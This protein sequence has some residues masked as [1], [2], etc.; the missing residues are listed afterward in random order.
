SDKVNSLPADH[1]AEKTELK[2][3]PTLIFCSSG[4][5]VSYLLWGIAQER[6]VSYPYQNEDAIE[7]GAER[8]KDSLFLELSNRMLSFLAALFVLLVTYQPSHKAPLYE[9]SYN[10]FTC[11]MS[12]WCQYEA[13]KYVSFPLQVLVKASKIIPVMLMGRLVS[14]KSYSNF[15]YFT[16]VLMSL[17]LFMFIIVKR[18]SFLNLSVV[19][20]SIL[21]VGYMGFDSFTSNWQ[22]EMFK[23]YEPSHIHMM[24]GTNFFEIL[25]ASVTLLGRKGFENAYNFSMRHPS[26]KVHLFGLALTSALGQF[27]I[28]Y[29]IKLF[30][31]VTFVIIMTVRQA[32]SVAISC[33]VYGHTVHYL[34]IFGVLLFFFAIVLRMLR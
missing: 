28:F 26:F 6:L 34:G 18:H 4:L 24:V 2:K 8:F 9:Y 21:M 7:E 23:R 14:K 12:S 19:S 27:F 16:A 5:V 33:L 13:L 25:F 20:G 17:G 3:L 22:S 31:P 10:S 1:S 11:L 15:E 32:L 29:T 30:G